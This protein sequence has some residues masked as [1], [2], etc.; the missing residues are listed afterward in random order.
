M[1][2]ESRK[3][4]ILIGG[5]SILLLVVAAVFIIGGDD[6]NSS[7]Q[8]VVNEDEPSFDGLSLA[9][10]CLWEPTNEFVDVCDGDFKI[11]NKKFSCGPV[12]CTNGD[13]LENEE[14]WRKTS[15]L[16]VECFGCR[17]EEDLAICENELPPPAGLA[18]V[19]ETIDSITIGWNGD[20][21]VDSYDVYYCIDGV[22][23]D[24][25]T[26]VGWGKVSIYGT[27]S[28]STGATEASVGGLISGKSYK[29]KIRSIRQDSFLNT[30]QWSVVTARTQDNPFQLVEGKEGEPSQEPT[31]IELG[32]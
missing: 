8:S 21:R 13:C 28:N 24:V 19:R 5:A 20:N 2:N 3:V 9:T 11:Q 4:Y 16:P 31:V 1:G 18:V 7:S 30:T 12:G 32:G 26:N 27:S 29:L 14:E 17:Q 23:C 6:N 25:E 15:K 22:I 10:E